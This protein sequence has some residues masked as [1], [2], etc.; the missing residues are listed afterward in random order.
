MGINQKIRKRI[1]K[2]HTKISEPH[3]LSNK[4]KKLLIFVPSWFEL[5][6]LSFISLAAIK[7][8][9]VHDLLE[10]CFSTS[11]TEFLSGSPLMMADY[12]H[13]NWTS[14]F[15][16]PCINNARYMYILIVLFPFFCHIVVYCLNSTQCSKL[17]IYS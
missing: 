16:S 2:S 13:T 11:F 10:Q 12:L 17:V 14:S 5:I 3:K 1:T 15:F 7:T 4:N 9:H 6:S 8:L